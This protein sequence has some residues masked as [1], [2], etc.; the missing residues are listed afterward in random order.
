MRLSLSP[1]AFRVPIV[2]HRCLYKIL[3]DRRQYRVGRVERRI[4]KHL[5]RLDLEGTLSPG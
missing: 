2:F 3:V 5:M 4:K 1:H